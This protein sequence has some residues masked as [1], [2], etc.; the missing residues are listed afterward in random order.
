MDGRTAGCRRPEPGQISPTLPVRLAGETSPEIVSGRSQ[1]E[2]SADTAPILLG[3][4]GREGIAATG[5][6]ADRPRVPPGGRGEYRC[7]EVAS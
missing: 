5:G 2:S 4:V 3:K 6:R 1:G 7:D